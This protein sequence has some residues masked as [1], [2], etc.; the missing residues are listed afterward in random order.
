MVSVVSLLI[1]SVHAYRE[2]ELNFMGAVFVYSMIHEAVVANFIG[3]YSYS[4]S[5]Q[6]Q[7]MKIPVM[8]GLSWATI[9]YVSKEM[10][11]KMGLRTWRLALFSGVMALSLDMGIDPI[12]TEIGVWSWGWP[13]DFLGV[14][15]GNFFGWFAISF[16]FVYLSSYL[17]KFV[18]ENYA[19]SLTIILTIPTVLLSLALW[20]TAGAGM[21]TVFA[22]VVVS[23][24]LIEDELEITRVSSLLFLPIFIIEVSYLIVGLVYDLGIYVAPSGAIALIYIIFWSCVED[25]PPL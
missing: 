5:F 7:I 8:I 10:G 19:L 22:L 25:K 23:L 14:P 3:T 1:A 17:G 18:K 2:N 9:V 16:V 12:A 6:P 4:M 20:E 21:L 15:A 24:A 13:A 11:E